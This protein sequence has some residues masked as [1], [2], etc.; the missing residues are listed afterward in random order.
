MA[1]AD[2]YDALQSERCYKSAVDHPRCCE[3]IAADRGTH[4]DPE[5]V[6]AFLRRHDDFYLVSCKLAD[7]TFPVEIEDLEVVVSE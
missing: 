7:T 1:F 3:I 6:D 4:F 2:V 5:V